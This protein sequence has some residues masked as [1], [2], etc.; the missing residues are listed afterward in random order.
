M[1]P[2]REL[3]KLAVAELPES[4]S[5]SKP[6]KLNV[7]KDSEPSR[8]WAPAGPKPG[9]YRHRPLSCLLCFYLV[10]G[11][12]VNKMLLTTLLQTQPF[13]IGVTRASSESL[14]LLCPD[15]YSLCKRRTGQVLSGLLS[16]HPRLHT[17]CTAP[18][19]GILCVQ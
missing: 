2:Y 15:L 16:P 3:N 6:V 18:G 4:A 14:R 5:P 10:V 1:V 13:L 9:C 7:F 19:T 8:S 11:R 17:H 12:E